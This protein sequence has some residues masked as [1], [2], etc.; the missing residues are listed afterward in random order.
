[1][2][3]AGI[4]S[5]ELRIESPNAEMLARCVIGVQW[6]PGSILAEL[7]T[8]RALAHSRDTVIRGVAVRG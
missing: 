3:S 7:G 5:G 6:I 8:D 1:M 2:L 4:R